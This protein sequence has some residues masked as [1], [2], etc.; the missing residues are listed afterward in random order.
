MNLDSLY[1]NEQILRFTLDNGLTVILKPDARHAVVSTQFWVKTGSIHEGRFLGSGISHYLEHLMFKGTSANTGREIQ[2][3]VH[4]LGGYFN[5]YT[6]FDRTVYYIDGPSEST[7][8]ILDILSDM[9]RD[10]IFPVEEV[11]REKN[12]ILREIDMRDDDPDSIL[13]E[14]LF[15]TAFREHPYKYPIIGYKDLFVKLGRKELQEYY[16]TRYVPNNMVLVMVGDFEPTQVEEAIRRDWEA[17]PRGTL[18]DIVIPDEYPVRTRRTIHD[19]G[20]YQISRGV[21]V[22]SIPGFSHPDSPA[23]SMLAEIIGSGESSLLWQDL[24][25]QQKLVHQ[26]YA[27][28]WN[29]GTTG[30]FYTGLLCDPQKRDLALE[31]LAGSLERIRKKGWLDEQWVQ[32]VV[33]RA[34]SREIRSRAQ[35]SGQAGKLGMAECVAGDIDYH[36]SMLKRLQEIT[37]S[38]IERVAHTWLKTEQSLTLTLSPNSLRNVESTARRAAAARIQVES[39]QFSNGLRWV[40]LPD[41]S[42]PMASIGY[43]G[44]GGPGFDPQ[45]ASGLSCLTSTLLAKDT[46]NRSDAEIV[47]AIEGV[48]GSFYGSC[49]NNTFSLIANSLRDDFSLASGLLTDGLTEA[50]FKQETFDLEKQAQ[51]ASIQEEQDDLVSW[52]MSRLRREFH[53]NHPFGNAPAGTEPDVVSLTREQVLG[54]W[55]RLKHPQNG[56][57]LLAGDLDWQEELSR[58]ET[59][60]AGFRGNP[61]QPLEAIPAFNGLSKSQ[62]LLLQRERQQAIV[63]RAFPSCGV[64]DETDPVDSVLV[65]MLSGM[66]S[67]L[68]ERVREE[69]GLAYFVSARRLVSPD[70]GM[71]Y[72]YAGTQPESADRVMEEY[73]SELQRLASGKWALSELT[74]AQASLR[75]SLRLRQQNLASRITDAGVRVLFGLP[76]TPWDHFDRKIGEVTQQHIRNKAGML[77]S[78]PSLSLI[79]KP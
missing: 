14:K 53:G 4:Q 19:F 16:R 12:V 67:H 35:V 33:R 7:L 31:A 15:A 1:A 71:F 25:Q 54:H 22:F 52:A 44:L 13:F 50:L 18:A 74:G 66:A 37:A 65:Q 28:A 64:R 78:Q 60:L 59:R 49:G 55:E 26:V 77:L 68:F 58:L 75:A 34:V 42:L 51:L 76:L 8:R 41:S 73:Q 48:G 23:L 5:A 24:R 38:D 57:L 17:V 79:V 32:Q 2:Q 9:M 47:T 20:D 46:Q 30:L 63:L 39:G 43:M 6:S 21:Q 45:G 10:P 36:R 62:S 11:E 56:V 69:Q 40:V 29:T 27:S 70:W 61:A 72:F 3:E